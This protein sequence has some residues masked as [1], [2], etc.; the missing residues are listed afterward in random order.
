[1][2]GRFVADLCLFLLR[3]LWKQSRA[4]VG[5]TRNELT[6][7]AE[8]VVKQLERF[9]NASGEELKSLTIQEADLKL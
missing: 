7:G 1:M 6:A 3:A 4:H 9:I 2:N 5:D 8:E